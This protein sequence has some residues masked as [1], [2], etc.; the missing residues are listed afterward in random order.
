MGEKSQKVIYDRDADFINI[1]L[2]KNSLEYLMREQLYLLASEFSSIMQDTTFE[3]SHYRLKALQNLMVYTK[4]IGSYQQFIS[5]VARLIK[6]LGLPNNSISYSLITTRLIHEGYLSDKNIFVKIEDNESFKD[7]SGYLGIDIVNGYG[8]CRHVS[9]IHQ[10]IFR[11]LNL[12]GNSL[13]CLLSSYIPF[14]EALQ[15]EG[16]HA[17]NLIEYEGLFYVHDTSQQRFYEFENAFTMMP[18]PSSLG[19]AQVLYYK[20]LLDM[21]FNNESQ[22]EILKKISHFDRSSQSQYI[23]VRELNE[24]LNETNLKYNESHETLKDF[25]HD[26]RPYTKEITSSVGIKP[27]MACLY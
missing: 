7:L 11:E 17:V 8:C 10:D 25:M 5:L 27:N 9:A 22:L 6:E 24:I 1:E 4:T 23:S 26:A 3:Q 19:N 20:P 13:P 12:K 21:I 16:N 15:R 18:Y 2:Q 14:R